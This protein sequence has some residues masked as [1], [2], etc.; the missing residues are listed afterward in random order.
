MKS[1]PFVVKWYKIYKIPN[2]LNNDRL[3][4]IVSKKISTNSVNRNF[5]KRVVREEF[6]RTINSSEKFSDIVVQMRRYPLKH[7]LDEFKAGLVLFF[8]KNAQSFDKI[9]EKNN[10]FFN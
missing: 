5:L 1:K 10:Y 9:D 2:T 3:G 6:R 8:K 7:E 4:L